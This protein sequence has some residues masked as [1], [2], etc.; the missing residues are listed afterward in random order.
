MNQLFLQILKTSF[1]PNN[2]QLPAS[3]DNFLNILIKFDT[4][5]GIFK[6]KKGPQVFARYDNNYYVCSK[7]PDIY[8]FYFCLDSW[9]IYNHAIIAKIKMLTMYICLFLGPSVTNENLQ[10]FRHKF[11][12][13]AIKS[14]CKK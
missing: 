2:C 9:I 4:T 7:S 3:N 1:T 10:I 11:I 6:A 13:D 12:L 14:S 5:V 8:I